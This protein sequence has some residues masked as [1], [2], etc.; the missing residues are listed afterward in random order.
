MGITKSKITP[1]NDECPITLESIENNE[2]IILNCKHQFKLYPMQFYCLDN[3]IKNSKVYCPL[4]RKNIIKKD[5]KNIYKKWCI[6]KLKYDNWKQNNLLFSDELNYYPKK[7]K[8]I[9]TDN[10]EIIL[11]L[12]KYNNYYQSLMICSVQVNDLNFAKHSFIYSKFNKFSNTE[13]GEELYKLKNCIRAYNTKDLVYQYFIERFIHKLPPKY[14]N[15][16]IMREIHKIY[17]KIYFYFSDINDIFT[18]DTFEGDMKEHFVLK[19]R[20]CQ[21]MFNTYFIHK[22]NE[23]YLINKIYSIIYY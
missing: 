15:K 18:F 6:I 17:K 4:C 10:Y 14:K 12:I 23:T 22:N 3:I 5:L 13:F 11:P 21:I 1:L 16:R 2:R 20:R 19:K 8:I 9:Q 7:Y